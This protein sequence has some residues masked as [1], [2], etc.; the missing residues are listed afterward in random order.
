MAE[1]AQVW[2]K[3]CLG[4][5]CVWSLGKQED[6]FTLFSHLLSGNNNNPP[7]NMTEMDIQI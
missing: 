6:L 7:K 4:P 3:A 2:F 1:T 5:A